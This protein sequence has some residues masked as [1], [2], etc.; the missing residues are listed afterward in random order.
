MVKD[1]IVIV[2]GNDHTNCVGVVQ[3][4][5][6][7]G[8]HSIG[9]LFGEETG[10]VKSSRYVER[11]ITGGTPQKCIDNLLSSSLQNVGRIPIIACCDSAALA[12][13]KNKSV[14]AD[15]YV[16]EYSS[17]I[18]L[19]ELSGKAFQVRL[20]Q[21][22]GFNVP[23]SWTLNES[24]VIPEEV[25]YPCI[26]KPIVSCEGAKSDIRICD[27][28]D[29]LVHQLSSLNKT[30][31]VILQQYIPRDYE[32]SILGCSLKNGDCIIPAVENKLSLFPKYV[33]LECLAYIEKLVNPDLINCINR[34][35]RSIG[36]VGLFSIELMHNHLDNKLYFTE[37]N[38][39]ND[40]AE[41]FITKYGANL[42]LNHVEDLLGLPI[43][44]QEKEYPG[45]YIWD[46]HH[47]KSL[48]SFDI[49]PLRWVKEIF[50]S[51]GFLMYSKDDPRPFYRQYFYLLSK[52]LRGKRTRKY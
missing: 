28:K 17:I 7:A 44:K 31:S 40:G 18:P 47:L 27:S 33:G 6:K 43:T 46:M 41:S 9:L 34:L 42:P 50:L 12:L 51:R 39:R 32:I 45:Y 19:C 52:A 38:F 13:E 11:I 16:F 1:R 24:E 4:L 29:D 8:F 49:S 37:I 22:A 21:E 35:I 48:F 20:A 10:L 5:S 30:K 23:E 36:Y 2:F 3:S 14:L 15:Y 25:S 26:I